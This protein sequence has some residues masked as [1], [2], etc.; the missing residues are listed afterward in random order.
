MACPPFIEDTTTCSAKDDP[1]TESGGLP[2][3]S[4]DSLKQEPA[5]V[6]CDIKEC[7]ASERGWRR[8]CGDRG[9]HRAGEN[10]RRVG[11]SSRGNW[12]VRVG[13]YA[14]M[15]SPVKMREF[16]R[17][18]LHH[19]SSKSFVFDPLPSRFHVLKIWTGLAFTPHEV[20]EPASISSCTSPSAQPVEEC[21]PA[22]LSPNPSSSCSAAA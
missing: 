22:S 14:D 16:R 18:Y 10:A 8:S 4:C 11:E 2:C 20:F 9:I 13:G 21:A 17:N 3:Q 12:Y 5:V 6:M 7:R 15:V 1:D 19:G